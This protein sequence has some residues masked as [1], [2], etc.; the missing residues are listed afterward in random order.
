LPYDEKK[1]QEETATTTPA[2]PNATGKQSTK[3]VKKGL[4]QK[5]DPP[6]TGKTPSDERELTKDGK[7]ASSTTGTPSSRNSTG[8][9][10]KFALQKRRTSARR[11]RR[12]RRRAAERDG[13]VDIPQSL[14]RKE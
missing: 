5:S 6:S 8:G 2:D 10:E 1:E 9:E 14:N 3:P 12:P 11:A 4:E 7:E 13:R